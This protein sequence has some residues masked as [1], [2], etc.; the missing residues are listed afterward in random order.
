MPT[1]DLSRLAAKYGTDK[2]GFHNYTPNYHG[3]LDRYRGRALRV[4]EIGVGGYGDADRGGQSLAMWRDYFPQAKVVGIDIQRKDFDLG[5]RVTILRGSQIDP[6]FLEGIVREHGPFDIIIDDGSHQNEHVIASFEYLYPTLAAGGTYLIEDVQ[7]A[8]IPRRGGSPE[9]TQPNSVGYFRDYFADLFAKPAHPVARVLRFHNIIALCKPPVDTMVADQSLMAGAATKTRTWRESLAQLSDGQA[10][11]IDADASDPLPA[12]LAKLFVDLDHREIA[13]NF[14]DYSADPAC[15]DVRCI[16]RSSAG[17]FLVKG[18]ND[19]PS[20]FTFDPDHPEAREVLAAVERQ[21]ARDPAEGG[22]VFY[23]DLLTR[24]RGLTAARPYLD[25]LAKMGSNSRTYLKMAIAL[26]TH[27][28]DGERVLSQ[29]EMLSASYPDD[30]LLRSG[31]AKAYLK[32]G[33]IEQSV[34]AAETAVELAP[35]VVKI[36][37]EASRIFLRAGLIDQAIEHARRAVALS[38]NG[39]Q[40]PA[41]EVLATTLA[42]AGAYA[43]A[44]GVVEPLLDI[45]DRRQA[46]LLRFASGLYR[47]TGQAAKALRSAERAVDLDPA[48]TEKLAWLTALRTKTA[49]AMD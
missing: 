19:Y 10:L 49:G 5:P 48:S 26:A 25:Q 42:K 46:F 35:R 12:D 36:R 21:L 11:R 3:V 24:Y 15:R 39:K 1:D 4:L 13:L 29:H 27:D 22:L 38:P 43:E 9:L 47:R 18:R 41:R 14:P 23:A 6:D 20:N 2:F 31:L 37:L 40:G 16:E 33:R 7:T 17:I 8:F 30:A 34:A 32:A 44:L 45:A 28:G